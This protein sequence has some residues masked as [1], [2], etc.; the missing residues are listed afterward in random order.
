MVFDIAVTGPGGAT[1]ES[2]YIDCVSDSMIAP[3]EPVTVSA[4]IFNN[5][6]P[7]VSEQ[8]KSSSFGPSPPPAGGPQSAHDRMRAA[9]APL[10]LSGGY[11][12]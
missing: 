6:Y 2:C 11:R 10:L 9:P 12:C 4:Q 5:S 1:L 8:V 7:P 3:G